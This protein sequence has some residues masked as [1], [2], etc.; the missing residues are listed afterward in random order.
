MSDFVENVLRFFIYRC[1]NIGDEK[2]AKELG[3]AVL[4]PKNAAL[5]KFEAIFR[6]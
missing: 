6:G 4:V 2:E 1:S 3:L 5:E